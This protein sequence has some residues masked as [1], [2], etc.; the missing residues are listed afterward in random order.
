MWMMK[1]AQEKGEE[2]L[3]LSQTPA[4]PAWA[5]QCPCLALENIWWL[6]EKGWQRRAWLGEICTVLTAL[7]TQGSST[8]AGILIDVY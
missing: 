8:R 3:S 6:G 4:E 5:G 7:I 2:R 1:G